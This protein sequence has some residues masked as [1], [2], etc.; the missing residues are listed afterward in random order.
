LT[1]VLSM[2]ATGPAYLVSHGGAAFPD[3]VIILQAQGV[4]LDLVGNT[5]IKKGITTSTFASAPDAPITSFE[6]KLPQGPHSVLTANLPAGANGSVC[7]QK[8]TMP[9][10]LTGQNNALIKQNTKIT[11]TGCPKAQKAKKARARARAPRSRA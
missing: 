11:I 9:T 1:P 3:L 2:P 10:T 6:L 7:G 5:S 4:R 8:L